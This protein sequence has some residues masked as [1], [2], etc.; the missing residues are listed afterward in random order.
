MMDAADRAQVLSERM[1]EAA[2][3]HAQAQ[4]APAGTPSA[5]ECEACGAAIPPQRQVAVP[6]TRHCVACQYAIERLK[7]IG[8]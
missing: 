3:R 6:G 4:I 5:Q 8:R 2:A 1:T 7:G